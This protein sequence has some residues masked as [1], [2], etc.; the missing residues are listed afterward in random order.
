MADSTA[1][2][3]HRDEA[4]LNYLFTQFEERE[5]QL[6]TNL[7]ISTLCTT[8]DTIAVCKFKNFGFEITNSLFRKK[9]LIKQ[10]KV[11]KPNGRRGGLGPV[12]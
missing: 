2:K 1:F 4:L 10:E 9:K 12:V 8:W 6:K 11:I 3:D 7:W 5:N